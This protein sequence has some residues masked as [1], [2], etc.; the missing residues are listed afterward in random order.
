VSWFLDKNAC[1]NIGLIYE[2]QKRPTYLSET[3]KRE[4]LNFFLKGKLDTPNMP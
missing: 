2:F 1:K 4:K 3:F